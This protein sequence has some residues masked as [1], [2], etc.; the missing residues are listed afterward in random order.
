VS[1]EFAAVEIRLSASLVARLDQEVAR[2]GASRD[3]IIALALREHF[4]RGCAILAQPRLPDADAF[5]RA[6]ARLAL[7]S[8]AVRPDATRR[9]QLF[10]A[11]RWSPPM[12]SLPPCPAGPPLVVRQRRRA[13]RRRPHARST[14]SSERS[15]DPPPDESE[16]ARA[17][18]A[19]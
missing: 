1:N 17:R 2:T 6:R 14:R 7:E 8:E 13:P 18:G 19:A 12:R 10:Y 9:A 11:E 3:E 15:G 16:P 5:L 4:A